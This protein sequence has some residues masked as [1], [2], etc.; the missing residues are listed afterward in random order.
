MEI[1]IKNPPIDFELTEL[2]GLKSSDFIVLCFNGQELDFYGTPYD[3]PAARAD[4]QNLVDALNRS[5]RS[6]WPK[7]FKNWKPEIC[8]QFGIKWETTHKDFRPVVTWHISRVCHGYS[9][10]LHVAI[11]LFETL[12]DKI[13]H[14]CVGKLENGQILVEITAKNGEVFVHSGDSMPLVIAQTVRSL[15]KA[16]CLKSNY[17]DQHEFFNFL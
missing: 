1:K 12:A 11:R 4:R 14:W 6:L 10:H 8:K 7:M 13:E 5:K 15:L 17:T 3:S 9:E 2:L 16:T